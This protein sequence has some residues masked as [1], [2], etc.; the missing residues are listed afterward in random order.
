MM[1]ETT[2]IPPT[3]SGSKLKVLCALR[4]AE[5]AKEALSM[6]ELSKVAGVSTAAMTGVIDALTK[7]GLAQRRRP[8]DD[9]RTQCVELTRAGLALVESMR[10]EG[11]ETR[12]TGH[13]EDGKEAA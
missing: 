5:E 6:T 2:K 3:M 11:H 10:A 13:E 8:G 1:I 9:R 7:D 12:G 4:E